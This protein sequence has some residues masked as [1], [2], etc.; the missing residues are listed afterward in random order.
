MQK[1]T[2]KA[3][4]VS[5]KLSIFNVMKMVKSGKLKSE[6]IE[7][8]GKEITYI[9]MDETIESEVKE[10]IVSAEKTTETKLQEEMKILTAEV[11]LLRTEIETLKKKL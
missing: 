4:A 2:I 5:H 7:E 10:A 8:N 9:I 11:Q 3:Y 1:V 6:V